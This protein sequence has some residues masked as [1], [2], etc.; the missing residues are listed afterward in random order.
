MQANYELWYLDDVGNRLAYVNDAVRFEYTK[1]L[2]GIGVGI[3][4][5]PQRGQVYDNE[6]VD[7]RIAIYRQPENGS[8]SLD[9]VMLARKF[10]TTTTSQ[11][12]TQK[13]ITGGDFNE[14]LTRRIIATYAGSSESEM[15]GTADNIMKEAVRDSFIDNA[16]YSGTAD[17]SRSISDYGFT[18][19]ADMSDGAT[20]SKGFAWKNN[21]TVLQDIQADSK[22][23][24]REVFFG[25]IPTSET[26][27]EFRTW[28]AGRDRT[29]SGVNPIVFS[30]EWGN[31]VNPRLVYDSSNE[32]NY[33]YG[34]GQGKES[35][36]VIQTASDET[37]INSSRLNRRE[38]FAFSNGKTSDP[39]LSDAK[40]ELERKRPTVRLFADISSTPL[41][42]YGG[43]NGW[44]LGDMIT[45]NYS[46]KQIDMLI[47]AVRVVVSPDGNERIQGK[48]ESA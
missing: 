16:D 28:A 10:E 29:S 2:G 13:K 45:V 7:R 14:L 39:V 4:W 3:I 8:L 17:P 26:T 38:A 30:L 41:T 1:V 44:N 42:P 25:I 21:N 5:I 43:L 12:Q 27:M 15:T 40:T 32:V 36:R 11:G 34:G 46:G 23:Q 33:V 24:G 18:V 22:A 47:R 35:E 31:L 9:F 19:Q 20:L 6:L 37:R 48:V